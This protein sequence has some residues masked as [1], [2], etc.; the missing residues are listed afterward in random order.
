MSLYTEEN[1]NEFVAKTEDSYKVKSYP[2]VDPIFNFTFGKHKLRTILSDTTSKK[3]SNHAFAPFLKT[4]QKTPR[5]RYQESSDKYKLETKIRPIS[6]A[7]HF[8]TYILGFYSYCLNKKYQ[9]YIRDHNFSDPIL[10][11]RSDLNGKCNIQFAKDAF[12]NVRARV[13]SKGTCSAIALDIKGYFDHIDHTILK[14]MWLKVIDLDQLPIDQYHIF[15]SITKYSYINYISFLKHFN[16]NLKAIEKEHKRKYPDRQFTPKGYNSILDLIPNN[17]AGSSYKEKMRYL[18]KMNLISINRNKDRSLSKNGI[19]QGSSI[20]ALLSN[21]YLL[22]FDKELHVKSNI[23]GFSYR[24]YCDDLL[25]ICDSER[26]NELKTFVMDLM[27]DKYKLTIQDKKT[28]VIDFKLSQQNKV[29]GF[30]RLYNEDTTE[31]EELP[32]TNSNFKSLQYLGFEFNGQKV[33]IRS[34]SLS[35]YFRKLKA[36]IVK[37]VGMSYSNNSKSHK[38]FKQQIYS[39][40]SHFGKRNFLSY[41]LNAAKKEYSYIDGEVKVGMNSPAIKKQISKHMKIIQQ[42][43]LKTSEQRRKQKKAKTLNK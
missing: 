25:I 36:R 34:G 41:A 29:R 38:I 22:D 32:N 5:Y 11:Y 4:L 1:W 18:R 37:S 33:F 31:F 17:Y 3:V 30:K 6:F 16:I 7:S 39:R 12:D 43:I 9:T 2:H 19:P 15:R 21:I 24:R 8:D 28:E 13:S 40:Y 23:E 27:T 42:E 26:V 10:A 35:R 14:S 20:S